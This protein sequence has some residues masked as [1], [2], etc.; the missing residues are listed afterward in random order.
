M[1]KRCFEATEVFPN[2]FKL[3]GTKSFSKVG[4]LATE[5]GATLLRVPVEAVQATFG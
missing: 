3:P 5:A 1:G 4:T 2:G